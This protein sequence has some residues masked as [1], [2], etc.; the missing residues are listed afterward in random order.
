MKLIQQSAE[1]WKQP[2][3]EVGIYKQVEK[4]ARLCYSEDTEVLTDKGF[5]PFT[6]LNNT[7]SVLTYNQNNN[8]LEWEKPN[9]FC[10]DVEESMIEINHANI[11]LKVTQNHRILQSAPEKREYS[12]LTAA[13]LAGIEKI[14]HSNQNRF[15]LPKYFI[16]AKRN[17]CS[18]YPREVTHSKWIKQGGFP[19]HEDVL[20]TVTIPVN[21]DFMVIAGAFISEGHTNHG[22][23]RNSGS[24]CQITQS[25]KSP[26]YSKVIKALNNLG[27]QYRQY[28]DSRKPE[29]KW[30]Q[31]GGGQCFVELFDNLFGK[32]SANMHLPEWFRLLPDN[33]LN[34]LLE[35]LYLG[36]GTHSKTRKERYLS[37]SKRLL[38]EIQEVFILLGKNASFTYDESISQKCSIEE[39]TRD[40]WIVSR[41]KHIHIL[42][43]EKQKVYC[44]QTNNGIICTRYK[45]KT[46]WCGNCYK[47]EDKITEDS[48]KRFI[49]MISSK[50]HLSPFE[51]GTVYLI[52]NDCFVALR[53]KDNPYS[54][55]VTVKKSF[56]D[57][58]YYITSNYRVLKEHGWEN[59]LQYLCK[60]TEYHAKRISVHIVTSRS[61]SHELVRHRVFSFCQESQRYCAYNKGKFGNEVTFVIPNWVNTHCPNEEQKGPSV[62]DIAFSDACKEAEDNYFL[63][64]G[65]GW[66]PQQAREVL[67]NA[68]KTELIMTGYEDDW[69][70]FF[71]LR[72]SPAA[73]PMM[74]ELA[75]K[76]KDL[77]YARKS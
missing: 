59:D 60:P 19:K 42:P 9:V 8:T 47:S 50:G 41:K 61:I 37:I 77:I 46:C 17:N 56:T 40:S 28:S 34:I 64:L 15:R 65:E 52:T 7:Y 27:W 31:F 1:L 48:Y 23:K 38:Q 39:S 62:A 30:I 44:T 2:E 57:V 53:Y 10:N 66:K 16:G 58:T 36:D 55:T 76:I 6:K 33:Y 43:K 45:N 70:E 11:K 21:E 72:C 51:H 5:I 68:T 69:Q 29:I 32:G 49:D 25:E 67:P 4:A 12:F 74:Q 13:Q 73:H 75:N 3:G 24:I 26:L 22:E 54:R 18:S 14:P 20:K 35:T 71:K 63:L